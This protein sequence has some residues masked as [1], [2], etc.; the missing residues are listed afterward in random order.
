MHSFP[1]LWMQ[2]HGKIFTA[3]AVR[4]PVEKPGSVHRGV[5]DYP[6]ERPECGQLGPDGGGQFTGLPSSAQKV[7][8]YCGLREADYQQNTI[9]FKWG[10]DK[11]EKRAGH[12]RKRAGAS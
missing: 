12:I 7:W 6:P 4:K 1:G 9:V 5:Y 11:R 8:E 10:V 2:M 3:A